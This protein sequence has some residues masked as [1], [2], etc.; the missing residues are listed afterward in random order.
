MRLTAGWPEVEILFFAE[1][2]GADVDYSLVTVV[3]EVAAE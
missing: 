3:E 1:K 2:F